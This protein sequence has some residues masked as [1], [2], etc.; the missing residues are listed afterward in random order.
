MFTFL[1]IALW[2]VGVSDH[3]H[4][5]GHIV[6]MHSGIVNGYQLLCNA[7]TVV[8]QHRGTAALFLFYSLSSFLLCSFCVFVIQIVWFLFLRAS[9]VCVN[10][11]KRAAADLVLWFPDKISV[12]THPWDQK[13]RLVFTVPLNITKLNIFSIDNAGNSLIFLVWTPRKRRNCL[14]FE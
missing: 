3:H 11:L 12:C 7:H 4:I 6:L 14:H 13:G 2:Y 1:T 9:T 5:K 8:K 10:N